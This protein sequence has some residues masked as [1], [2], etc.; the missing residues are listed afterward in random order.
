MSYLFL[1]KVKE[2]LCVFILEHVLCWG[3]CEVKSVPVLYVV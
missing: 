2:D 1:V 3:Y